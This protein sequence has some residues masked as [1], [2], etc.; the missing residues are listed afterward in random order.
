MNLLNTVK[1]DKLCFSLNDVTPELFE[2]IKQVLSKYYDNYSLENKYRHLYLEVTPTRQNREYYSG[3]NHNLQMIPLEIFNIFLKE[4]RSVAGQN[5]KIYGIHL[6]KDISV[7]YKT[8]EYIKCLLKHEYMNGYSASSEEADTPNTA[9]IS[10]KKD[11]DSNGKIKLL[12]KFYNKIAQI[13]HKEKVKKLPLKEPVE[14]ENL[15]IETINGKILLDLEQMNCLRCE[16][17]LRE[18]NLPYTTI[19]QL[20]EAIEGGTF[21]DT[22]EV[23]Y[24]ETLERSVFAEPKPKTSCSK[25]NEIAISLIENSDKNYSVL[26]D[27]A[28]MSREYRYFRHGKELITRT[29]DRY[30]NELKEELLGR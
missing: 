22:V 18:N 24:K 23:C 3:C 29:N 14:D 13:I 20:I 21:Q 28:G 12:I 7:F 5:L 10:K 26:F 25:L 9:Y 2:L 30:F 11:L 8:S 15:P 1:V 4:L 27:Q 17:E 6:A 19:E 16:M